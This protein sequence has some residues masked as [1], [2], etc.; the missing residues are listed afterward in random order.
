MSTGA[1]VEDVGYISIAAMLG[2][3][4][5]AAAVLIVY[6]GRGLYRCVADRDGTAIAVGV[7]AALVLLTAMAR[8][9]LRY[10][11]PEALWPDPDPGPVVDAGVF[12]VALL[13]V[14]VAAIAR[15]QRTG[16]GVRR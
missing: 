16:P 9:V 13:I 8:V 6:A 5:M 14:I 2:V 11:A 7:L 1:L 3:A 10:Y 4:A 12:L 15:L